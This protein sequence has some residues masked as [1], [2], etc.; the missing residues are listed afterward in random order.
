MPSAILILRASFEQQLEKCQV[1]Y[2]NFY[3]LHNVYEN[4][5]DMYIEP[6]WGIIDYFPG[7]GEAAG[8]HPG[9]WASPLMRTSPV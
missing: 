4:S 8:A 2:F 6:K 7:A 3:L 9:I 1:E 5:I